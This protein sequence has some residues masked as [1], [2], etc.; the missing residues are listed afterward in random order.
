[1][2]FEYSLAMDINLSFIL[3]P[4]FMLDVNGMMLITIDSLSEVAVELAVVAGL[5]SAYFQL[6]QYF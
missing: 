1:M 4:D 5:V 2:T 3:M 6:R